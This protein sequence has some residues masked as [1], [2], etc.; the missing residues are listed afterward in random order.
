MYYL[1]DIGKISTYNI[2]SKLQALIP[3]DNYFWTSWTLLFPFVHLYVLHQTLFWTCHLQSLYNVIWCDSY[4]DFL[5]LFCVAVKLYSQ[6]YTVY[7]KKMYHNII[8]ELNPEKKLWL[9]Q[10]DFIFYKQCQFVVS[11]IF[12]SDNIHM[13]KPSPF[14]PQ[15]LLNSCV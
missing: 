13:R 6:I 7:F 11:F 12:I 5:L 1:I 9:N 15:L 14:N 4:L 8:K 2:T 10:S 3:L